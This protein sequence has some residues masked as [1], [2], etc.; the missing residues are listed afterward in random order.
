M[1]EAV[2]RS[3]LR[4]FWHNLTKEN[5]FIIIAT[6][7]ITKTCSGSS[8]TRN[9][10]WTWSH[11]IDDAN[12]TTVHTVIFFFNKIFSNKTQTYPSITSQYVGSIVTSSVLYM[13]IV[14][15]PVPVNSNTS[16]V[17]LPLPSAGEKEISNT[18]GPFTTKS[19]ARYCKR[20]R[21]GYY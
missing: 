18:P 21:E 2:K 15:P 14:T 17:S 3:Q 10:I 16:V 4:T 11:A 12:W 1:T 8:Q 6:T 20:M 13:P 19:L 9:T 7:T 5:Y